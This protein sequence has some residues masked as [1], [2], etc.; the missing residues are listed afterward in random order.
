[1]TLRW[2]CWMVWRWVGR[3]VIIGLQGSYTSLLSEHLLYIFCTPNQSYSFLQFDNIYSSVILSEFIN[4]PPPP[5]PT[6]VLPLQ[7]FLCTLPMVC[8]HYE[9]KNVP[10]IIKCR[11]SPFWTLLS[12][13]TRS[14]QICE[15]LNNS[16]TTVSIFNPFQRLYI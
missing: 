9:M 4:I 6:W 7:N 2:V 11:M 14:Y 10:L 16:T 12:L 1:M 3:S 15:H 5:P 8:R 13:I